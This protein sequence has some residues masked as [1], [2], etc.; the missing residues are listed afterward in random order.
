[1]VNLDELQKKIYKNKVDKHFNLTNIPQEFCYL[2]G[3]VAEAYDAWSK[4]MDT[5]TIG[6]ELADVAIFTLGLAE[7]LGISLEDVLL[8]K[9]EI[10][11]KRVY[12]NGKKM[13][14]AT[15]NHQA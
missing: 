11:D 4:K 15:T 1:M 3:E 9:I 8:K 14:P 12:V 10:N 7:M 6:L 5:A 2:Y 13:E